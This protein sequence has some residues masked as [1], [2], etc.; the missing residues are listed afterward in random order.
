MKVLMKV[1]TLSNEHLEHLRGFFEHLRGHGTTV[2][3]TTQSA[4]NT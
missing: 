1:L 2:N 4:I 3:Q